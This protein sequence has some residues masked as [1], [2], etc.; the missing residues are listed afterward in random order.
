M[1]IS[2]FAVQA[3]NGDNLERQVSDCMEQLGVFIS[4]ASLSWKNI[5]T[6]NFFLCTDNAD[7]YRDHTRIVFNYL[8]EQI[9]SRVP[10]ACLAQSPANG[11]L[12]SLEIYYIVELVDY[13]VIVRKADGNLCLVIQQ[14]EGEKLVIA[15][16]IGKGN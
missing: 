6:M 8:G 3:N 9:S 12:V 5:I 10:V 1:K 4:N 7:T 15:N 11:T 16:G 2:A 13:E 14:R